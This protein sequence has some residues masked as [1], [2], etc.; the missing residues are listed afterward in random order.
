[1]TVTSS[2]YDIRAQLQQALVDNLVGPAAGDD[3]ICEGDPRQRYLFGV[4]GPQSYRAPLARAPE[5][6]LDEEEVGADLESEEDEPFLDQDELATDETEPEAFASL[7]EKSAARPSLVPNSFGFT[8]CVALTTECLDIHA[9]WARY[10]RVPLARDADPEEK[11]KNRY[12]RRALAGSVRLELRAA[13][14]SRSQELILNCPQEGPLDDARVKAIVRARG[15]F[16]V[17]TLFLVNTQKARRRQLVAR[18]L[19]QAQMAVADPAG[20]PV[21]L[22]H[23]HSGSQLASDG[24][25]ALDPIDE[26]EL[27]DLEMLHRRNVEFAVGH[28]IAVRAT[29]DPTAPLVATALQTCAIP[30]HEVPR[31]DPAEIA[32]LSL[33]MADLAERPDLAAALEPLAVA[34]EAW[35]QALNPDEPSLADHRDR[36]EIARHRCRQALARIRAGIALLASDPE[37]A[38]CFRFANRAMARQRVQTLYADARRR[39]DGAKLRLADFDLPANHLWRPFQLA[40]ILLNLPGLTQLD[41]PERQEGSQAVADLL[42]FPTGG[43]KTEAYLGL[44]AYTLALRRRQASAQDQGGDG[45]AV[46]MRYTLRL[47]TH[48]QYQRAAALV[49]ACEVLRREAPELWGQTPFRIGLW[50]GAQSTPNRSEDAAEL[51]GKCRLGTANAEELIQFPACPWC[52]T[53]VKAAVNLEADRARARTLLYCGDPSGKCPF[54]K[55]GAAGEGL[56]V[57]CV[58]EEIFRLL[59]AIVVATVDKFAQMPLN[60]QIQMLFGRVQSYCPRHGYR[61]RETEDEDSHRASKGLPAVRSRPCPPLRPPDLIIQDELHLISGPLGTLVGIYETAVEKL[62]SWQVDGRTVRPKLILSTATIRRAEDQV[63]CLF[64]HQVAVFPP[65]GLDPGDNFFAIQRPPGPVHPGRLY[66]GVCAP[67][68]KIKSVMI[69]VYATVL[70]AAQALFERY[71]EAADPYMTLVGYFNSRRELGGVRRMVD[72]AIMAQARNPKG[73]NLARRY[74]DPGSS[75]DELTS[76]LRAKDIPRVLDQLALPFTT[77]PKQPAPD[78]EKRRTR[79]YDVLLATNM[80]QVGVDVPRL[81]LMVV[82]RQPKTTSEYI[83]ATSRIGRRQPG[84]VITVFNWAHPR[85]LS[86]YERFATFHADFNRHVEANSV[87]PFSARARDRALTAVLVALIRQWDATYNDNL[88]AGQLKL[89]SDHAERAIASLC[90]RAE[91]MAPGLGEVVRKELDRR[92]DFWVKKAQKNSQGRL[93][94]SKKGGEADKIRNLLLLAGRDTPRTVEEQLFTVQPSLRSVEAP[95]DLVLCGNLPLNEDTPI[96]RF[97]A[98]GGKA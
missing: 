12:Q 17:I 63:K 20:R 72:D 75:V 51:V 6:P 49:C 88:A 98:K 9:G 52:G 96:V 22:K 32:G 14:A 83:Q 1:M 7:S 91:L 95:V 54:T 36:A 70:S 59:P 28:G 8:F 48:Q 90:E 97:S 27:A 19:F 67:G 38:R 39:A 13:E 40:F 61:S 89:G 86:H 78:G 23:P 45:V 66:L 33:D 71:G 26:G 87:T 84:L 55:R 80:I 53:L 41:H 69:R 81:G 11:N 77:Q 46:L 85:D 34:Y 76:R 30:A 73:Q 93:A 68:R 42:F 15:P 82:A 79:P 43:G 35:I 4:L 64:N 5:A 24:T 2:S 29:V 58:D 56:P 18:H 50:V 3:E 37:A 10:T 65:H 74:L 21:F 57:V 94:Y 31:T 92:L 60:G 25:S 47:L 16:W 62:A 44:S